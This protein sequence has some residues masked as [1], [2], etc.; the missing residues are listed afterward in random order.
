MPGFNDFQYAF[1]LIVTAIPS[2][3]LSITVGYFTTVFLE[4][5]TAGLLSVTLAYLAGIWFVAK[6]SLVLPA[7]ATG[8]NLDL[9][10]AWSQSSGYVLTIM[11]IIA[12]IPLAI[13]NIPDLLNRLFDLGE[14]IYGFFYLFFI[15]FSFILP[16]IGL[17]LI[18][19]QVTATTNSD[20]Q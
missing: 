4:N 3:L 5:S 7:L 11:F 19:Q 8:E 2:A 1:G 6:I 10:R 18:Y 12:I 13:S 17:A 9:K 14:E 20:K 16:A 15:I